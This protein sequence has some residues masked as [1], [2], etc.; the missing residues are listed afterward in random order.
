LIRMS[1]STFLSNSTAGKEQ[2]GFLGR[3]L[4][5]IWQEK[6]SGGNWHFLPS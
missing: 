5:S 3:G 1:E 4:A 2:G 6:S